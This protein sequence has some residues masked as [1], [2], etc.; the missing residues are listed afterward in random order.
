MRV[1]TLNLQINQS[2]FRNPAQHLRVAAATVPTG[3]IDSVMS[4]S[5]SSSK[6]IKPPEWSRRSKGTRKSVEGR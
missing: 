2:L 5:T 3:S 1:A 4:C 6:P